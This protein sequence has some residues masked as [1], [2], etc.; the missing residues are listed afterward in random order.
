MFSS[1][2]PHFTIVNNTSRTN[3]NNERY[4]YSPFNL[5]KTEGVMNSGMRDVSFRTCAIVAYFLCL[6]TDR[7]NF[8][9]I[10]LPTF[11]SCS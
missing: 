2:Q 1:H 8:V 4:I 9:S 10:L 7:M 11:D 6:D 3:F 5:W